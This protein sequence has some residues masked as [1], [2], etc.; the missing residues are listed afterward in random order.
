[1]YLLRRIMK[2]LYVIAGLVLLAVGFLPIGAMAYDTKID[3][4][5]YNLITKAKMAE[6]TN[7]DEVYSGELNIPAIGKL[8]DTLISLG[9]K[10]FAGP[11]SASQGHQYPKWQES[12]D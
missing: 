4:I 3:G 8:P 7:G 2:R 10:V 12:C 5:Y 6:V 1:M 11:L 9:E